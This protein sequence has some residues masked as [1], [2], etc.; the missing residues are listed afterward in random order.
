MADSAVSGSL[1]AVFKKLETDIAV[2]E[3]KK[4]NVTIELN[5]LNGAKDLIVA[6]IGSLKEQQR[7]EERKLGVAKKEILDVEQESIS[8]V[9]KE[10]EVL[11]A[12]RVEAEAA[13]AALAEK[14]QSLQDR[15]EMVTRTTAANE[16]RGS[17]LNRQAEDIEMRETQVRLDREQMSLRQSE[18]DAAETRANA[19]LADANAKLEQVQTEKVA[20]EELHGKVQ[21]LSADNE[22]A[23]E[24]LNNLQTAT[25]QKMQKAKEATA[26]MEQFYT[27]CREVAAKVAVGVHAEDQSAV[28]DALIV[29][30][31]TI[32]YTPAEPVA[33]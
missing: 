24:Q 2:L 32:G 15:E 31:A 30:F 20:V 29:F 10:T 9:Q 3:A 5:T 27:L 33:V 26:R 12:K 1:D 21:K 17:A 28:E 4:N 16:E 11:E 8:K 19:T 23:R 6:E 13:V 14:E 18:T 25:D 22:A 7:E